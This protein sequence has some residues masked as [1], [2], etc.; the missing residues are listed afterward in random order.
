MRQV[1]LSDGTVISVPSTG[2]AAADDT[3]DFTTLLQNKG[4]IS[5]K[6]PGLD[7]FRQS[8]Q[9]NFATPEDYWRWAYGGGNV[10]SDPTTGEQYF[11]TPNG[12]G[13]YV[14]QPLNYN[15]PDTFSDMLGLYLVGGIAGLGALAGAGAGAAGAAEGASIG[16]FSNTAGVA[17]EAFGGAGAAG[18]AALPES[19]WG[20]LADA[21]GTATDA[22]MAGTV[23]SPT[24]SWS[25]SDLFN[26][27]GSGS[28]FQ[29]FGGSGGG[30]YGVGGWG[31]DEV[32][33][34]GGLDMPGA[35]GGTTGTS[36][37][38]LSNLFGGNNWMNLA[39][40]LG[41]GLLQYLAAQKAAGAQTDA[42]NAS[43][44]LLWNMYNQNR[45]DLEPWRQAGIGGL[46]NLVNL[47]TPGKQFDQMALDPGYQFR[48]DE[49]MKQLENQLRAAGKFYSGDALKAGQQ[50][51]QGFASNEFGNVFNR[52][53]ALAG[54]GQTATNTGVSAGQNTANQMG[55][56]LLGAG[57]ARASGYVGGANAI[58]G[59]L[60]NYFNTQNQ[61]ALL[62]ALLGGRVG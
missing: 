58:S 16:G 17:G 41:G 60:S 6:D 20:M 44:A 39:G 9:G 7:W 31:T 46:G 24:Q 54:L 43:N 38:S 3:P 28:A 42:T 62:A 4:Y 57:N 5:L 59:S 34:T 48:Y 36:G 50:Y 13:N 55:Q 15:T 40:S 27:P 29:G 37:F 22:S 30:D 19:Y 11:K 23:G 12:V 21:G 14:N 61:N 56:N 33:I 26:T 45:A 32:G 25:I 10:A 18:G 2:G 8:G 1:T 35:M 49:G 47:T 51:G 53:A 52:N